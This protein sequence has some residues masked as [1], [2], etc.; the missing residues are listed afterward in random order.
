[1]LVI[2]VMVAVVA[3]VMVTM[4]AMVVACVTASLETSR[5]PPTS[6]FYDRKILN[7]ETICIS[8]DFSAPLKYN[9]IGVCR[10]I[11]RLILV[12]LI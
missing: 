11:S 12:Q 9:S 5:V 1:M 3:L 2:V 4:V 6:I 8:T 10:H 7:S